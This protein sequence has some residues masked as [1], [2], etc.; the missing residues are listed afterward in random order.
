MSPILP[1]Y[2][3]R[4]LRQLLRSRE[5]YVAMGKVAKQRIKSLLLFSNLHPLLKDTTQY[6][7]YPHIKRLKE[8]PCSPAT[9]QRLNLLL[10]D[11]EYARAQ[12]LIVLR[13]LKAFSEKD[14]TLKRNI[15][16]LRTIPGIGFIT[17][18]TILAS[19][20]DPRQ[21]RNPRELSA[22]IG[23]VPSE[24]STGEHISRGRITH[25]GNSVLRCLLIESAW[26][27]IT[28]DIRMR[29]FYERIR[30]KHHPQIGSRKAIVAVARKLTLI[31]YRVL[32]EQREYINHM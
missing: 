9:R 17:A 11:L 31:I 25:L 12:T 1:D 8:L 22:F 16:Y 20:G 28:K 3:C 5:E 13:E 18:A 10:A 32:K 14:E 30:S 4:E 7:S 29:Q 24:Y 26:K 19:I 23:L 27:N 6:W 21:L 15:I 2:D